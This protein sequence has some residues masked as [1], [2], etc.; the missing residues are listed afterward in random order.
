[1]SSSSSESDSDSTHSSLPTYERYDL[2]HYD[3]SAIPTSNDLKAPENFTENTN[4]E[5]TKESEN[6]QNSLEIS[7]QLLQTIEISD[8]QPDTRSKN[9]NPSGTGTSLNSIIAKT[10][11]FFD[12]YSRKAY[13]SGYVYKKNEY[14][15]D[16]VLLTSDDYVGNKSIY[17]RGGEW[18][19]WWAELTGSTLY[20]WRVPDEVATM[21]YESSPNLDSMVNLELEPKSKTIQIIK[22]SHDTPVK[23]EISDA[24]TELLSFSSLPAQQD[25]P[26]PPVPYT[27][28]FAV[29][30][31]GC[32]LFLFATH[33]FLAA[34]AWVNALRL[35]IYESSLINY[36]FTMNLLRIPPYTVAWSD[37]GIPPFH[38]AWY[39]FDIKFSGNVSAKNAF[40]NSWKTYFCS[41]VSQ[42]K[43]VDDSDIV[44]RKSGLF[45]R[46][47]EMSQEKS[48]E[49]EG[50]DRF[51]SHM[52]FFESKADMKKGLPP[53]MVLEKVSNAFCIWPQQ[54]E[55]VKKDMVGLF[56]IEGN[57]VVGEKN[58]SKTVNHRLST[59]GQLS[60]EPSGIHSPLPSKS[61]PSHVLLTTTNSHEALRWMVAIFGAFRM[62]AN[63]ELADVDT[64][65]WLSPPP[66]WGELSLNVDEISGH[67]AM[68]SVFDS[69][70][71]FS[72]I[73]YDKKAILK[74]GL[75]NKWVESVSEGLEHRLKYEKREV[76][77]KAKELINWIE[78]MKIGVVK[79]PEWVDNELSAKFGEKAFTDDGQLAGI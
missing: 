78:M 58:I 3:L 57:V 66:G 16:G 11:F 67:S 17:D 7:Q 26:L 59:A 9:V 35:S 52:Y 39:K 48:E 29:S 14:D 27:S 69:F 4:L 38:S 2:D 47:K 76:E 15:T 22:S 13:Y 32:N 12:V 36:N 8:E 61:N 25:C 56:K 62:D 1:M 24:T 72:R 23:I 6:L 54:P 20:L 53:I 63:I 79:L 49:T 71:H 19:K 44:K 60:K 75:L 40:E 68:H 65:I 21:A 41:I 18:T 51:V 34:N 55:L 28:F 73:S 37:I 31:I 50:S 5:P 46:K 74:S 42:K 77:A 70:S 64:A 45:G 30:T 33:S 43:L 10:K